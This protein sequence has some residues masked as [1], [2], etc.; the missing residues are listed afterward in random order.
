MLMMVYSTVIL[1]T[2]VQAAPAPPPHT[3]PDTPSDPMIL[4][5]LITITGLFIMSCLTDENLMPNILDV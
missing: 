1:A 4:I 3:Q 2:Q 5:T